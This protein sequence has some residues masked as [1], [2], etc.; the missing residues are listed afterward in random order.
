MELSFVDDARHTLEHLI[1]FASPSHASNE[2]ITGWV[3]HRLQELGFETELVSY[4][5]ASGVRKCNVLGYR[6]GQATAAGRPDAAPIPPSGGLAYFAHTDVVPADEWEGPGGPFDPEIHDGRLYG[7]GSCD[8]KGSL[9]AMLA[10]VRRIPVEEQIAPL[11]IVCTADEEVGF[12][13]A[14]QVRDDSKFF[15]TMVAG[16]PVGIVGEP[17][18]LN[19][20]HAHK[21]ITGFKLTSRGRAA[22]SSTSEGRNA[23]LAMVPLL[24]EL[25]EIDQATQTDPALRDQ[26]FEPPTLSWNFGVSDGASAVNVTPGQSKAWGSLRPMPTI[27]GLPLIERVRHKA[28]TLGILFEEYHGGGYLWVEPDHPWVQQMCKL[29]GVPQPKTASYCTDAGQFTELDS[30]VVCG[31]GDIAQAHTTDEYIEL[32]QLSAG[33]DLYERVIRA[34]CCT[35]S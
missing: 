16:Q 3:E 21:G 23:N 13:G 12:L 25:L 19:V 24:V 22:H 2:P 29:A 33:V 15:R 17:T 7:R 32:D 6:A 10:A 30:L 20:V 28:Q 34:V 11:W 9:A 14:K 31:P 35:E 8:M 18:R 5:D 26:R 1:R 27:D 4:T